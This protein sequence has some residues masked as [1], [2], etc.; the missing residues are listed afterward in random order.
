MNTPR[1]LLIAFFAAT[2]FA[3][4]VSVSRAAPPAPVD[5]LA[6]DP[7]AERRIK[8]GLAF[9]RGDISV[10][11]GVNG[12]ESLVVLAFA[13][14]GVPE[15]DPTLRAT[16]KNVL[17]KFDAY[18]EYAPGKDH[19]GN[20]VAGVEAMM[21]G[22]LDGEK[23][24]PQ[25]QAIGRHLMKT[26]CKNGSWDYEGAEGGDTSISQYAILGLWEATR[27]GLDVP[28]TTWSRA[29]RW[30]IATQA[31][32]GG[33]V[34]HPT[35][36]NSKTTYTMTVA[37]TGS[38]LVCR[39]HLYPTER[40][41][42]AVE[43]V[44]TAR[45]KKSRKFG[46]LE[47]GEDVE[48]LPTAP[49]A[50]PAPDAIVSLAALKG[51]IERGHGWLRGKFTAK[52]ETGWPTYYLYGIE[53]L[54]ALYGPGFLGGRDWYGEGQV[55]LSQMQ[56]A[57]GGLTDQATP[58]GATSFAVLFLVRATAKIVAPLKRVATYG[59]G[60]LVGGRGLPDNLAD[61]RLKG[62]TVES[63][64]VK[65]PV[66]ELLAQLENPTALEV[67]AQQD[68]LVEQIST[69][70]IRAL[71]GQTDRLL[72][73]ARDKRVEVRRTAFWA[74]GRADDLRVVPVLIEALRDADSACV[75]EARN[76]LQ[77][78]SRRP[79]DEPPGDEPSEEQKLAA[80]KSWKKWYLTVRPYADRDDLEEPR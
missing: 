28:E 32:D 6:E 50:A 9:L 80:V 19:Y 11:G 51:S 71:V 7:E 36:T 17:K 14:C 12:R 20:Y 39:R 44:A 30:H 74:L 57:T 68:Q 24:R 79:V 29:A 45:K 15:T 63:K 48:K 64:K 65:T 13:K 34:Y 67:D 4:V 8:A 73:L 75:V 5:K 59:T 3:G 27:H 40:D 41:E 62:G 54:A 66:E 23:Y 43:S 38:L 53:R 70:E 61:A 49:E 46:V 69:D 16:V 35:D 58:S 78:L 55:V 18:G 56:A 31:P 2:L 37:G 25:I 26:Q 52:P 10:W 76:A 33:F 42:A 21:L 72:K 1:H 77:F 47:R 22:A 60:L